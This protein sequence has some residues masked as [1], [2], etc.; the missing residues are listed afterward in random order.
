MSSIIVPSMLIIV[1]YV[2][3]FIFSYR[4]KSRANSTNHNQSIRLAKGLFASFMLF[5]CCW[6]P[7]GFLVMIDF[8]DKAP[9]AAI[10][11]TMTFAH[12]N[13][14]FNPI[15]YAVFNS[16]FKRG[17]EVLFRRAFCLPSIAKRNSQRV[18]A[19]NISST[20]FTFKARN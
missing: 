6:M 1:F 18:A 19:I 7:F 11:Y 3:I 17:Y 13:S 15:L 16:A 4:S 5:A 12:L 9:R 8:A 10:M 20:R 14:A 2:K